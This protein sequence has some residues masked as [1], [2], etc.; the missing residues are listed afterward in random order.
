MNSSEV[1]LVAIRPAEKKFANIVWQVS[2]VCNYRCSYCNR[3][4]WG[5]QQPNL[6][7][8]TY[9]KTLKSLLSQFKEQGYEAFKIFFSGGEP[10]YWKPLVEICEFLHSVLD[11]P[12]IAI[13]T[14]MSRSL[15]WWETHHHLF[16]DVVASFHI[17]SANQDNYLRNIKYLQCR[18]PYV[19]C[20]LLMHDERFEEVVKFSE[21]IK[22]ELDNY[23]IE[24]AALFDDLLPHSPMHIYKE[25]WKA[26]FLETHSYESQR[27]LDF[28]M[29]KD[30][31]SAA[32]LEVYADGN[33]E[34]LN[35][36]RLISQNRNH[37]KGW[38]CSINDSI[39]INT[40]GNIR[41]ASCNAGQIIGNIADENV[42]L[43]NQPVICPLEVCGCGTDISIPK[44][45]TNK[46]GGDRA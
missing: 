32:C 10:T 33:V 4:N 3:G 34:V 9:I 25:K 30:A 46:S 20:R 8:K 29:I 12:L 27:N 11:R 39:F 45:R 31:K 28:C 2:D 26:D 18:L 7:T 19:A 21:R 38:S 36:T 23:L 37:F 24:Y 41:L 42:K 5:G 1:S 44:I 14:N 6:D 15:N 13:N 22:V 43:L 35:A 16:R 40:S 17:E